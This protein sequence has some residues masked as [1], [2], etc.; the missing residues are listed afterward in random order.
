MML[1]MD[2]RQYIRYLRAQRHSLT[3]DTVMRQVV[4]MANSLF[5]D[6]TDVKA[7]E[8][9]SLLIPIIYSHLDD[10]SKHATMK[11]YMTCLG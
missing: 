8:D 1:P 11:R 3:V 9:A 7:M 6:T 2:R 10:A 5:N 4:P